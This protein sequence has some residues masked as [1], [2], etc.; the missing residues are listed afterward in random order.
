VE[1]ETDTDADADADSED[2]ELVVSW[3]LCDGDTVADADTDGT[4]DDE[5]VDVMDTEACGDVDGAALSD[6]DADIDCDWDAAVDCD[7]DADVV[8]VGDGDVD[9][10]GDTLSLASDASDMSLYKM[11]GAVA[12]AGAP[13]ALS[14][15]PL[16]SERSG[17]VTAPGCAGRRRAAASTA[18]S[19][20]SPAWC[21]ASAW[22]C[23][24]DATSTTSSTRWHHLRRI[25]QAWVDEKSDMPYASLLLRAY[26]Y[27]SVTRSDVPMRDSRQ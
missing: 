19:P 22:H 10:D 13:R 24:H 16:A 7:W 9:G 23:R 14:R 6:A 17:D 15:L 11:T 20:P 25:V 27:T 1:K 5:T 4:A 3:L 2:V 18:A 26:R 8:S 21:D 12:T